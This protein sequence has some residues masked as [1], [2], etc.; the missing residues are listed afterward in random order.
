MGYK[1]SLSW[2]KPCTC[3]IFYDVDTA[4]QERFNQSTLGA[5]F[6]R[7]AH[8]ALIVYDVTNEKS[9]EQV[10]Q[11]SDEVMNKIEPGTYFPIVVVGNKVDL[12]ESNP[13]SHHECVDQN[14]VMAW[15]QEHSHGHVETSVKDNF[16]VE[17][18][19]TTMAALALEAHRVN[20]RQGSDKP[21]KS[22]NIKLSE[23]YQ[24]S[25]GSCC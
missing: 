14:A 5:S 13:E 15:C 8:G 25:R 10:S 16:G 22:G 2:N 1:I 4:G 17:A 7:G 21:T 12:R 6:Y 19:M 23:M 9:F 24:E 3:K 11:W 18:A 20:L